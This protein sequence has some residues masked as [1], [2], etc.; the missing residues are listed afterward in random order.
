[1]QRRFSSDNVAELQPVPPASPTWLA[2][3]RRDW[4][5]RHTPLSEPQ[6]LI[7]REL[8]KGQPLGDALDAALAG[9]RDSVEIEQHLPDWFRT[10]T[11][12][13]LIGAV[14]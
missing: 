1:V 13:R 4:I 5:V 14:E 12:E 9:E 8:Q 6:F 7:L 2:V 11:I 10:W 3:H